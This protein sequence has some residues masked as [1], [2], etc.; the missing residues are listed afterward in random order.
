MLPR[1]AAPP[2]A[3]AGSRMPR[4]R[5]AAP[6]AAAPASSTHGAAVA[7]PGAAAAGT[8]RAVDGAGVGAGAE[9]DAADTD[10]IT[11]DVSE[12]TAW[13]AEEE[14]ELARL[15]LEEEAREAAET[16]ETRRA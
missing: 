5:P 9:T 7:F 1:P 8:R 4:R 3:T 12:T 10:P 16:R 14:A 11:S 2:A 15:L 6:P 13:S